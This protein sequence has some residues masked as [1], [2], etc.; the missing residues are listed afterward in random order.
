MPAGKECSERRSPAW[1]AR[2]H[3]V[4]ES[5]TRLP[6]RPETQLSGLRP[7]YEAGQGTSIV[8]GVISGHARHDFLGWGAAVSDGR[9]NQPMADRIFDQLAAIVELQFLA[10]M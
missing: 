10:D 8:R 1:P 7:L 4:V 9:V 5:C 3:I 6:V 2:Y